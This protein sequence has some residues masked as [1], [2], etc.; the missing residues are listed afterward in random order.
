MPIAKRSAQV[1]DRAGIRPPVSKDGVETFG[2]SEVARSG[3][4]PQQR[5]EID[6]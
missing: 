5:A 2:H 4:R 6:S 3:D 1:S